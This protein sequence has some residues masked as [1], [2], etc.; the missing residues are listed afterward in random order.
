M[1][2]LDVRKALAAMDADETVRERLAEGDFVSVDGLE[3]T[4]EEQILV[5]DAANDMPEVAGFAAGFLL[6]VEG[7]STHQDHKGF[8][9]PTGLGQ[10]AWKWQVAYKYGFKF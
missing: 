8:A 10:S 2:R 1:G 6:G 5:Q 7:E 3:L 9:L 4:A